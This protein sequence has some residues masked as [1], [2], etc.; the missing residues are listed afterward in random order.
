MAT[1]ASLA[2]KTH[3]TPISVHFA[4]AH[5]IPKACIELA[6]ALQQAPDF[7][8]PHLG[9]CKVVPLLEWSDTRICDIFNFNVF[10]ILEDKKA[11]PIHGFGNG[12]RLVDTTGMWVNQGVFLELDNPLEMCSYE[13][14]EASYNRIYTTMISGWEKT[15]LNDHPDILHKEDPNEFDL[16]TKTTSL[17]EEDSLI[18]FIARKFGL[19]GKVYCSFQWLKDPGAENNGK[20]YLWIK[21]TEL[22][23]AVEKIGF[24]LKGR[25]IV[26]PPSPPAASPLSPFAQQV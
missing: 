21:K 1:A 8:R 20:L 14:L 19:F 9:K 26:T 17:K 3:F 10:H 12:Y 25:P 11:W 2:P 4:K 7:N 18:L 6:K 13:T 16:F 15:D 23:T 22:D 5:D 24:Q